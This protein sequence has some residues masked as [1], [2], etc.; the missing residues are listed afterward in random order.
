VPSLYFAAREKLAHSHPEGTASWALFD[1]LAN[2][3]RRISVAQALGALREMRR[4]G[5]VAGGDDDRPAPPGAPGVAGAA[6]TEGSR[7]RGRSYASV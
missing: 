7:R 4:Q 6:G 1:E 3:P 2:D 5:I